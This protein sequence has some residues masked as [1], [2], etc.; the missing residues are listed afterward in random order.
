MKCQQAGARAQVAFAPSGVELQSVFVS[1]VC[2]ATSS[3]EQP[4]GA[5]IGYL[6]IFCLLLT[7]LYYQAR[8]GEIT[9]VCWQHWKYKESSLIYKSSYTCHI[10]SHFSEEIVYRKQIANEFAQCISFWEG[11]TVYT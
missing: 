11:N 10:E 1:N 5:R 8:V 9:A 3:T 4:I 6:S 2:L 7:W